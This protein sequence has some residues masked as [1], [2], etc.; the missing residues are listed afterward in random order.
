VQHT[1]GFAIIRYQ[2]VRGLMNLHLVDN[3]RIGFVVVIII[4]SIFCYLYLFTG[5]CTQYNCT[6]A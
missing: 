4:I 2:L 1:N 5:I 6:D 3:I